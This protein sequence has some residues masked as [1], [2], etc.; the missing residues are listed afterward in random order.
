MNQIL[1]F[2]VGQSLK[3]RRNTCFRGFKS[4]LAVVFT[5]PN[6]KGSLYQ[7]CE[8]QSFVLMTTTSS[9]STWGILV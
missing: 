8:L 5:Y 2:W 9:Q 4:S 7:K 3:S 1:G 6:L